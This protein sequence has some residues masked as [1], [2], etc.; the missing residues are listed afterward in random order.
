MTSNTIKALEYGVK[1]IGT[2]Y[3]YWKGGE[4][5]KGAPMFAEN[6]PLP[7]RLNVVSLNCAGLCNLMLR[8]LEKTLPFSKKT[9]TLGGTESYFEFYKNKSY[10]FCMDNIYPR[11]T[12]LMRDYKDLNDQG[13]VAVLLEDI[14]KESLVLQSH[15]E[16]EYF[17]SI[18]PGVNAMYTLE[19][20]N[21]FFKNADGTGC[22]YE[23]V[24]LPEDWLE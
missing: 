22:Y 17:K 9:K 16:G 7:H 11:G 20:S 12:L 4:N 23:K 15:V 1:L 5:Q 18:K 6:G 24:V 10:K 21:K 3:D 14:G 8:S 13:H 2:P 19:E